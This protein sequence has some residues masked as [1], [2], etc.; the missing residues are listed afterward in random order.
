MKL[1]LRVLTDE[2][3]VYRG[4]DDC[5]PVGSMK[6]YKKGQQFD[7]AILEVDLGTGGNEDW[8]AVPIDRG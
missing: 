1:R 6:P 2:E 5:I 3:F 8:Q 4:T 7:P